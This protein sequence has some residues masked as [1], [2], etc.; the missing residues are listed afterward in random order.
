VRVGVSLVMMALG[1]LALMGGLAFAVRYRGLG[2]GGAVTKLRIVITV[3]Q[4]C[5]DGG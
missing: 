5:W 4:V 3:Y 2:A 1:T